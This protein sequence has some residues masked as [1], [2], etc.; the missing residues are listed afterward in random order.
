MDSGSS[1]HPDPS[2]PNAPHL[3]IPRRRNLRRF[4]NKAEE[5]RKMKRWGK[6]SALAL[7]V[8][9]LVTVAGRVVVSQQPAP[10]PP[11][12]AN[13]YAQLFEQARPHL[14][15]VLGVRLDGLQLSTATP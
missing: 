9:G 6:W 5:V 14:E 4:P 1:N 10:A 13:P 11:A 3:L 15:A 7:G 2:F 12:V 8:V